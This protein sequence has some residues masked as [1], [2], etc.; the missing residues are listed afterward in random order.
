MSDSFKKIFLGASIAVPFLIYCIYYYGIMIKNAPYK[1]TELDYIELKGTVGNKINKFYNSKTMVYQYI[2]LQDKL[3]TV[4]VKLNKDDLLYLHR[5]AVDANFWNLP[6][7]ITGDET[8]NSPRYYL[9]FKYKRKEKSIVL[10]NKFMGN[11]KHKEFAERLVKTVDKT[12]QDAED[13][14]KRL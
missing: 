3:V 10:D 14:S 5:Q 8:A 4:K 6:T 7:D 12:V 11:P 13:R 2:N 9:T 1:F